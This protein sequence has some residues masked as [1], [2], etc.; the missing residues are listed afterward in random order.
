MKNRYEA[1]IVL[2]TQ[3][4]EET[5]KD[6]VDRLEGEFNK[7]GA[8]VEQVQKMDK[9]QFSY[10]AGE[11]DSGYFVNFI[12]HADSQLITKL[13]SKFKL[14]PE[15]YRQNYQRLPEKKEREPRAKKVA[16]AK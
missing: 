7:E 9:R 12:F 13:R 16:A 10:Q 8:E 2:N 6:I 4:K 11:L 3:G 14:D 1:L 15:V 5:V